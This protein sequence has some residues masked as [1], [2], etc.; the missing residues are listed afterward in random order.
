MAMRDDLTKVI[1][2]LEGLTVKSSLDH[3]QGQ[4]TKTLNAYV[5]SLISKGIPIVS[6]VPPVPPKP[7][8]A[9]KSL[10]F[11]AA[12]PGKV[13]GKVQIYN[14]KDLGEQHHSVLYMGPPKTGKTHCAMSWPDPFVIYYDPNLATLTKFQG[15]PFCLPKGYNE[16]ATGPLMAIQ[17]RQ[18]EARTIVLDSAS[19]FADAIIQEEKGGRAKLDYSGWGNILEK[20]SHTFRVLTDA[21]KPYPGRPDLRT[22]HLVVTCHERDVTDDAGS[23][24]RVT[25]AIPGQF[26]DQLARFFNTVL[27]TSVA[28]KNT[29]IPATGG[30]PGAISRTA[31]Y[32]VWTIP[33]DPFRACGDG[34]G[35]GRFK[36]LPIQTDGT[37]LSLLSGWGIP[38][39]RGAATPNMDVP[40]GSAVPS[41]PETSK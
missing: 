12:P 8:E 6:T 7:P 1:W 23:L 35:G 41:S 26:R 33:P 27:I 4:F 19:F 28:V 10:L 29:H 24:L 37:Y 18:I 11:A 3:L 25:P 31:S 21:T 32:K 17:N 9:P 15:V 20:L 13:I 22:Y 30:T 16:L 36:I 40:G 34:V 39:T 38:S 14:T 2:D 5:D